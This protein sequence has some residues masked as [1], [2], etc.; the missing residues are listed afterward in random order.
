M[1][2]SEGSGGMT[3]ASAHDSLPQT[4]G[5]KIMSIPMGLFFKGVARKALVQDLNDIKAA[6]EKQ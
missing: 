6:V 5:A 1:S 2:I 3:L 4:I